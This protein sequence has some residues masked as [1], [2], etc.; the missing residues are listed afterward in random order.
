MKK[1]LELSGETVDMFTTEFGIETYM[2]PDNYG[3]GFDSVRIG[4]GTK[5]KGVR[6]EDRWL[7]LEQ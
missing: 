2:R 4:F 5:E 6:G 1:C 3:S 7:P